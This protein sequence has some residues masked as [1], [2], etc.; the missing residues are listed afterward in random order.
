[1]PPAPAGTFPNRSL[2]ACW[3]CIARDALPALCHLLKL[4]HCLQLML[5]VNFCTSN[6]Q[7]HEE[8]LDAVLTRKVS[9][10][11]LP[12]QAPWG[13]QSSTPPLL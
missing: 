8:E 2:Y 3:T 10:A 9:A 6:I 7:F 11:V 12:V 13:R 5:S 4:C 1:M